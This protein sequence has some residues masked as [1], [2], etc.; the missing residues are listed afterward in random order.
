MAAGALMGNGYAGKADPAASGTHCG[1][2]VSS[3]CRRLIAGGIGG[4]DG[5]RGGSGAD[6]GT[7]GIAEMGA[8]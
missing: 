1:R 7:A 3:G 6:I 4:V 8:T 2:Q 5:T